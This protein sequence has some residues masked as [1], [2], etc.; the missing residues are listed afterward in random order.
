MI[1]IRSATPEER[2]A[3]KE[4]PG[5]WVDLD[6]AE[7]FVAED[8]D[9]II[10]FLCA[11]KVYH[12]EHLVLFGG[13][14][15]KRSRAALQLYRSIES[16]I[17]NPL[18]NRDGIRQMICFTRRGCVKGWADRLGWTRCFKRAATFTKFF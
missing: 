4:H 10:G 5:V 18:T 7:V 14:K 11:Q 3:W 1:R 16:F 17:R 8:K 6:T 12:V 15:V 13:S 2:T 9:E